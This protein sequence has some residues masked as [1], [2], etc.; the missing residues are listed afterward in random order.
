MGDDRS[1]V[2]RSSRG[3][4]GT[5][6]EAVLRTSGQWTTTSGADGRQWTMTSGADDVKEDPVWI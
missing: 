2:G 4:D 3:A 6:V 1:G 5:M